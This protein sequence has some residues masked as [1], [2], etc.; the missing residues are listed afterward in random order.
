MSDLPRSGRPKAVCTDENTERIREN[1]E[2]NPTAST[3]K[4]S[5]ELGISQ[6]S[7]KSLNFYP[8]KV[9]LILELKPQDFQP[10]LQYAVRLRELAK[11]E[12]NFFD[13][14]IMSDEAHF[15]LNG[16]VNKQ[17]CRFWAKKNPRAVHQ[18]ELHPVKC[19]ITA[20]EIIGPYFFEDDDGNA[21]SVTGERYRVMLRNFLW[22]AIENRVRMWFQQDGATPDTAR[23]SM[24]LLREH[25]NGRIIS[26]FG[27]INWPSRSPDLTSPDF[28]CRDI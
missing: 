14:L 2:E 17:N 12:S 22:P 13:I 24:Q 6:T 1:V 18:R 10:R 23:E 28:F 16:F 11:N 4:R 20:N 27:D 26:R 3:R 25:F 21:V 7:L 9:Q 15:H 8:Y 5:L 19:A